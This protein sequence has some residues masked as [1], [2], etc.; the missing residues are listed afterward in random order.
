MRRFQLLCLCVF[1]WLF[2]S[3]AYS[4]ANPPSADTMTYSSLPTKNYGSYTSLL[5]QVGA[6][7]SNS[8][9]QFNLS[10]LP[11]GAVVTKATLRLYVNQVNTAGSFDVYQL[12]NSLERINTELQQCSAFGDIGD[13]RQ[14][15]GFHHHDSES[16]CADR[17]H[18]AGA[19]LGKRIDRQ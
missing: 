15:G 13:G 14:S 12:D 4:Q 19:G 9:I 18:V 10:S 16:V 11:T 5:V 17:Y 8:Y 7:T 2:A 1:V 6:V 3:L